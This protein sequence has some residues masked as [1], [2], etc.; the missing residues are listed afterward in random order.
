M[1]AWLVIDWHFFAGLP[2]RTEKDTDAAYRRRLI[3]AVRKELTIPALF[4][5]FANNGMEMSLR[6]DWYG[7][8]TTAQSLVKNFLLQPL[9]AK[10]EAAE[11]PKDLLVL[12]PS[13]SWAPAPNQTYSRHNWLCALT[14]SP[15]YRR[16]I[17]LVPAWGNDRLPARGRSTS[18][19][20]YYK[21]ERKI[22]GCHVSGREFPSFL[23][24]SL[25]RTKFLERILVLREPGGTRYAPH[26]EDGRFRDFSKTLQD[27]VEH[28][29][30]S[31]CTN[32]ELRKS[33]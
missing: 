6:P 30:S 10:L 31:A 9:P 21:A 25:R 20:W 27:A 1:S 8:T 23:D 29:R 19:S 18:D 7:T 32:T 13:V 5:A 26:L 28:F 2:P 24:R 11:A 22:W 4:Q 16:I 15:R 12:S 3:K 33:A 14:W 17:N